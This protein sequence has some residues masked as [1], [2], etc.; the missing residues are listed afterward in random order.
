MPRIPLPRR[1]IRSLFILTVLVLGPYM[2]L[3]SLSDI[4][5]DEYEGGSGLGFGVFGGGSGSGAL[6]GRYIPG[7]SETRRKVN[8]NRSKGRTTNSQGRTSGQSKSGKGAAGKTRAKKDGLA[9]HRWDANGLVYVNPNGRHPI[10][11]L[12]ERAK[13]TWEEKL[14]KSSKTLR[15]AVNE[16]RRR[17]GRPPPKGFDRW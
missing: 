3:R 17:Y 6:G 5:D 15:E 9:E 10:Y 8:K 7:I 1:G 16:Y 12:I 14:D 2:V 4:A 11:D 13:E